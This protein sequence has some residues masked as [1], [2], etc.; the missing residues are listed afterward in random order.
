MD[1]II[2]SKSETRQRILSCALISTKAISPQI[3]EDSI[4][5][6]LVAENATPRD[7]ADTQVS[8]R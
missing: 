5:R 8:R 3:D 4:T 6:S 2:A 7:I 1:L